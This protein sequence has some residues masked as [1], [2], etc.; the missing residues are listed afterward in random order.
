MHGQ[1][2]ASAITYKARQDRSTD[3]LIGICRGI[4]ADGEVNQAETEFLLDWLQRHRQFSEAFPFNVLFRRVDQALADGR[5]DLEE[6]A[7]L[8]ET[9]HSVVGGEGAGLDSLSASTWSIFKHPEP[10]IRFANRDFVVTG[11][12]ACGE[13]FKVESLIAAEGGYVKK[14]LTRDTSYLLVGG[15]G[16]RDWKHSSFGR[17]IE[18][19]IHMRDEEGHYIEIVSEEHFLSQLTPMF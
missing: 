18:R 4:L 9:L 3:E 14:A 13:R 1:A 10:E 15:V 5:L 6:Q 8:L 17:K 19:A 11:R 16:S 2:P 7:D 12:F